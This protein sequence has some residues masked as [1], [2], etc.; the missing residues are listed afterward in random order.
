MPH[1]AHQTVPELLENPR[2]W[3]VRPLVLDGD[4]ALWRDDANESAISRTDRGP[5]THAGMCHWNRDKIGRARSLYIVQFR[6]WRGCISVP[7]SR[8]VRRAPGRID[9][10][11]PT[12]D[13]HTAWTAQEL[14]CR[15]QGIS[16]GWGTIAQALFM[17]MSLLRLVTGWTPDKNNQ[18]L[19]AWYDDKDCSQGVT[20][21]LRLATPKDSKWEILPNRSDKS[22][23]PSDL[24]CTPAAPQWVRGV[25]PDDWKVAA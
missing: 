24:G 1:Q 14:L 2:Y 21:A 22:A 13:P 17:R 8:E 16:Y 9:L 4:I 3:L 10:F 5:W 11:R 25:V 7:F 19:S 18:F 23:T 20:F 15:Q 12:C 6:E